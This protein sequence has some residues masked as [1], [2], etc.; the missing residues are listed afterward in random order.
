MSLPPDDLAEKI[1]DGDLAT[2]LALVRY[3]S[4]FPDEAIRELIEKARQAQAQ[5]NRLMY[6]HF[7]E[8][9]ARSKHPTAV[10]WLLKVMLGEAGERPDGLDDILLMHFGHDNHVDLVPL[11]RHLLG[12]GG[13]KSNSG[14]FGNWVSH[15]AKRGTNED[16]RMLLGHPSKSAVYYTYWG[17]MEHDPSRAMRVYERALADERMTDRRGGL[18]SQLVGTRTPGYLDVLERHIADMDDGKPAPYGLY[19][20]KLFYWYIDSLDSSTLARAAT[21][22]QGLRSERVR[23]EAAEELRVL[24]ERGRRLD[25]FRELSS[26]PARTIRRLLAKQ[27]KLTEEELRLFLQATTRT[28]LDVPPLLNEENICAL[29]EAAELWTGER[30]SVI[31]DVAIRCRQKLDRPPWR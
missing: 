22:L 12:P 4:S 1:R 28:T 15:L 10:D 5:R 30:A 19:R 16:R 11:A 6:L 27:D 2:T 24:H 26:Q 14:M 31:Q 23:L 20:D 7:A 18:L 8:A 25:A 17:I 21:F 13:L 9:L 3:R 29:E